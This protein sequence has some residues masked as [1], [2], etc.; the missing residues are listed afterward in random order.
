MHLATDLF[1]RNLWLTKMRPSLQ[2]DLSYTHR[3]TLTTK[4]NLIY[5]YWAKTVTEISD[6]LYFSGGV[7]YPV[8][9]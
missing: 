7:G 5:L 4:V 2:A 8:R 3:S 1:Y 9:S 6:M